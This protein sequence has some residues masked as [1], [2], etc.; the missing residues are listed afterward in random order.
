MVRARAPRSGRM[1]AA[2]GFERG[3]GRAFRTGPARGFVSGGPAPP[4]ESR[5]PPAKRIAL[6]DLLA[7]RRRPGDAILS[8]L[9]AALA[10][11]ALATFWTHTG[12]QDRALPDDMATYLGRQFGLLGGEGRLD[13]FGKILKQSWV[14]PALCLTVLVP[15]ALLNLRA[16]LRTRRARARYGLPVAPGFELSV[17]AR[18]LEFVAWFIAYTLLVPVAGYLVATLLMGTVLPWRLGYR[19]P[20]WLAATAAASLAIVLVFRTGLQIRTPINVPL[21]ALLPRRWEAFMQTWF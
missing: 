5:C 11:L 3:D 12:W 9:M 20:G 21:Y 10:L 18:A 19:G 8:G 15:A 14:G 6:R 1:D 17:W 13:R 7:F 16:S 2:R 4:F